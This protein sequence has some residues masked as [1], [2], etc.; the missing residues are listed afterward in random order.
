M[1][2]GLLDYNYYVVGFSGGKDSTACV[3]TLI[4]NGVPKDKIELWHQKIDGISGSLMDWAITNDYCRKFAEALELKIYF[5]WRHGGFEREML[6]N[7]TSTNPVSFETENGI[8]TRGGKG[9]PNTRLKFPQVSSNLSV[10]WCTSS[11]KIDVSG[12][13]LRN[14]ERFRGSKTLYITGERAEESVARAK[15]KIFEPHREDLRT[16]KK[17]QRHIDHLRPVHSWAEAMVWDII[18]KHG[19]VPHP[20]YGLGWGRLSCATC[21][22]GSPNQWASYFKINPKAIRKI[23]GYEKEFGVTINRGK[24]VWQMIADGKPYLGTDNRQLVAQALLKEYE[25]QIFTNQWKL[26]LGAFGEQTGPT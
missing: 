15:Y 14:Q 12:M 16:G 26:P 4:D 9:K 7:S 3:L 5:G 10:R 24:T 19:I 11:L 13:A 21:I 23:A 8:R 6:R 1:I 17:Y 25:L 22:F 20:A 2:K 18:Q